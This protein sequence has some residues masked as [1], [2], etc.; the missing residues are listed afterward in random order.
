M[1]HALIVGCL[2][3]ASIAHAS[4]G[5][6][7]QFQAAFS[8]VK[9]GM[10]LDEVRRLGQVGH[11]CTDWPHQHPPICGPLHYFADVRSTETAS[12]TTT[13]YSYGKEQ[14]VLRNGIVVLILR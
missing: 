9:V 5:D 1:K 3:G 8:Q 6:E 4:T 12:G 11:K 10:T 13:T 2:L 14:I 7:E